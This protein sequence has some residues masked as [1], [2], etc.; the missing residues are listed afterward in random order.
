MFQ[1]DIIAAY[2]NALLRRRKVLVVQPYGHEKGHGVV[3]QLN[4]A[5][6]GLR[7]SAN[8]WYGTIDNTLKEAGFVPLQADPCIYINKATGVYI[9]LYVDDTLMAAPSEEPIHALLD[10]LDEKFG[11][12]R[13]GQPKKFLGCNIH[14]DSSNKVIYLS[15]RPYVKELL[16]RF[17]MTNLNRRQVPINPGSKLISDSPLLVDEE[18]HEY[19]KRVGG[20]N[21]LEF[22]TRPDISFAVRFLQWK[23]KAPDTADMDR[24][25]A[26]FRYLIENDDLALPLNQDPKRGLELYSDSSHADHPDGHSTQGWILFWAGCP[27]AWGTGKQECVAPS[28]TC[29][30]YMCFGACAKHA[31][32]AKQILIGL[33]L[34]KESDS[35]TLYTDSD[36][37]LDAIKKATAPAVRWLATRFHFIRDIAAKGEIIFKL[38]DT[39]DNVAD[40]FTKPKNNDKFAIFV[41]QL[42]MER[43]KVA[44]EED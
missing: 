34:M 5:M 2:L 23:M 30:E 35:I 27:I 26:L 17:G 3:C 7:E 4:K 38:I 33:E 8:I 40:G 25:K 16:S 36:N 43:L 6:Y 20:F 13:I 41:K 39:K 21:W 31:L 14:I 32:Y 15:Q 37:A 11:M 44:D 22:K 1:A 18:I 12:K 24:T 9:L 28:S 42:R 10:H 19:F 29:A